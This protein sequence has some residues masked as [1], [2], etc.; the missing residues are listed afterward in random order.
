YWPA[1]LAWLREAAPGTWSRTERWV[2]FGD[3]LYL[4]LFGELVTSP[5]MASGT[6]L[7]RLRGGWDPELLAL[8]GLRREQLPAE[9]AELG[10][11]R[12]GMPA[13][14]GRRAQPG[15]R[16]P[17]DRRDRR[18][19][20][21]HHRRADRARGSGG[22]GANLRRRRPGARRDGARRAP[23]GRQRSRPAQLAGVDP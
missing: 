19:D 8:L 10:G 5:S 14:A 1:K 11:P 2:S 23:A 21:G 13:P 18:P 4:R 7:R 12:A 15:L 3:L 9:A 16:G 22:G 17:R 20:A 6:G